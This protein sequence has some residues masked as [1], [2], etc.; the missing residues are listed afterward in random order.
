MP[1]L[2]HITLVTFVRGACADMLPGRVGEL[3]YVA[4]LNRGHGIPVSDCMT[5]LSIGLLFDFAA[6]LVVLVAAVATIA[7][8]LSLLGSAIILLLVCLVGWFGLFHIM[9]WFSG[10]LARHSPASWL[11]LKPYA[12]AVAL[13]EDMSASVRFVA[14]SGSVPPVR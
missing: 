11:R 3:S 7:Q 6:L 5:S 1:G 9:P 13:L 12:W 10:L 14:K 2:W 4:M 8:G